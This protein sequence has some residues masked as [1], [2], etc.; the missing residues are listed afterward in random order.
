MWWR[1]VLFNKDHWKLYYR[2]FL[3]NYCR[4]FLK[5]WNLVCIKNSRVNL[6][7]ETV[8][9]ILFMLCFEIPK[10]TFLTHGHLWIHL[11][12]P[13]FNFLI[14]SHDT[15]VRAYFLK[16]STTYI[17]TIFQFFFFA[18]FFWLTKEFYPFFFHVGRKFCHIFML[19][20]DLPKYNIRHYYYRKIQEFS[21]SYEWLLKILLEPIF[22]LNVTNAILSTI[23]FYFGL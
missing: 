15:E 23:L 18:G 1:T 17:W 11:N 3:Q 20:C 12:W 9:C 13:F 5:F 4:I 14:I 6:W 16:G 8:C 21:H 19:C 2:V 7:L 22:C 10:M